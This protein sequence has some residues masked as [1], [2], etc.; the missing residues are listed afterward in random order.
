MA[1]KVMKTLDL[2][3][4]PYVHPAMAIAGEVNRCSAIVNYISGQIENLEYDS[5]A[6]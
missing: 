6:G 3:T 5:I 2:T 4:L 1:R